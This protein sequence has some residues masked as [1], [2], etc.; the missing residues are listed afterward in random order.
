MLVRYIRVISGA[1][2]GVRL[3]S[4]EYDDTVFGIGRVVEDEEEE[5]E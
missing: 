3:V 4:L 2:S 1:A 5:M